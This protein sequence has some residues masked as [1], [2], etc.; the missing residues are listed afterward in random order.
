MGETK[1][2]ISKVQELIMNY[3]ND[4]SS[5]KAGAKVSKLQRCQPKAHG[6]LNM[7]DLVHATSALLNMVLFSILYLR[8][9]INSKVRFKEV[10][11]K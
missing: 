10:I 8:I 11:F 6:G 1:H 5:K 4:R 7:I 3:F 2:G 9:K